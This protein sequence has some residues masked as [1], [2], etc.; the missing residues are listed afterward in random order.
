MKNEILDRHTNQ[1]HGAETSFGSWESR[2]Y[3]S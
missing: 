1:L 3:S 2:S